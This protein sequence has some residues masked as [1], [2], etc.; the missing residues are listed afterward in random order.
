MSNSSI[1]KRDINLDVLRCLSLFFVLAVHFL[2]HCGIYD[3]GY[4]G[5]TAFLSDTLRNFYAPALGIFIMLNGFLQFRRKLSSNYYLGILRLYEMYLVCSVAHILY[6]VFYLGTDMSIKDMLSTLLNFTAGDYSW[7]ILLY[8][9]LFLLI[10]FLNLSYNAI[11]H[12][13]QKRVL[14]L[15]LF[16]ISALPFSFLNAFISTTAYWWQRIWPLLFYF[17]GAYFGE[18]R[19]RL[20]AKKAGLL[21]FAVLM[22][23]SVYNFALYNPNSPL[24]GISTRSFQYAH[25]SL[26]IA[27]MA[28]LLFL[29]IINIDMSAC[30]AVIEKT[31]AVISKYTY[32]IFLF[33]SLT[34]SFIYLWLCRFV[35]DVG[36][37]YLL[38][39][40][41]VPISYVGATFMAFLADKLV[42]LMDKLI[43]PAAKW[44]IDTLYRLTAPDA[45]AAEKAE[46]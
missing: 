18:Y 2:T 43:R 21:Y 42:N 34:D 23:F 11:E 12:R 38:F 30:P 22:V 1:A 26:Q 35:P 4:T 36:V 3:A 10:P 24:F 44:L 16:F 41:A 15:S 7:Y 6:N 17:M 39:P 32:G 8:N 31:L 14:I 13:G 46:S 33:S 29:W 40:I 19:P 27:V 37:R 9:G 20:S 5:V 28:P 45:A 25:E